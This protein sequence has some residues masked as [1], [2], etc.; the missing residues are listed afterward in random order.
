MLR[1]ANMWAC[2]QSIQSNHGKS[3]FPDV[4][5]LHEFKIRVWKM[6]IF[7][8]CEFL[9]HKI[10]VLSID[11][12]KGMSH[13]YRQ[14]PTFGA[15]TI[16]K[17]SANSSEM[18]CM[19]THNFEDLLQCSIPVFDGLLPE[20][21]NWIVLKLLY[22]MA[23]WHGLAKLRMHSELTLKIMDQLTSVLGHQFRQFKATVC[24][25]YETHELRQ[26]VEAWS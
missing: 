1:L 4:D 8:Y 11:W 10:R 19:A 26:E 20:P 15:A 23:H 24:A 25:A 21:H 6:L 17:F 5:L 9:W 16:Q 12:T 14:T 3:R 7:T 18:K 13:R 2:C 22:T